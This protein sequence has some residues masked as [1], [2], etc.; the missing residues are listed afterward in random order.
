MRLLQNIN[1]YVSKDECA[2]VYTGR[3]VGRA[4]ELASALL[5]LI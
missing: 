4:E 5:E 1:L 2:Q 3:N